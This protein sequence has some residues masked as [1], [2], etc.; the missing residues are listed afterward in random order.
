MVEQM[1][2]PKKQYVYP[3]EDSRGKIW[4]FSSKGTFI[5]KPDEGTTLTPAIYENLRFDIGGIVFRK[6]M[7][8]IYRLSEKRAFY[9]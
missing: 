4:L 8:K 3:I 9:Y 6:Q 2:Y 7:A 1:N 5:F